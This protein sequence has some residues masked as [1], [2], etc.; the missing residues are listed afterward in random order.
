LLRL[1]DQRTAEFLRIPST[2]Q[3]HLQ[4][5]RY[6][7]GEK[8]D[9]HHDYFDPA[10]YQNDRE[11]L[12]M[13]R[14]GKRNRFATFFWY[15]SDVTSG[16]ET[17]FPKVEGRSPTSM[18]DCAG[19]GSLLVRPEQGK[20]VLFYSLTSAGRLDPRSIHGAC[21]VGPDSVKWAANKWVWNAPMN[22]VR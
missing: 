4:V 20:V 21:P 14:H 11:T 17:S 12:E 6:L 2:H 7:P 15:L 5:L 3:E 13:T 22:Y 10:L 8:Y 18:L 1:L 16:G 9:Q 19:T